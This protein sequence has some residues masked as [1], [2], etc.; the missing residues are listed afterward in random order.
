M[1]K[2]SY[3]FYLLATMGIWHLGRGAYGDATVFIAASVL[4]ELDFR[5]KH[6]LLKKFEITYRPLL[7]SIL[8]I[9]GVVLT[10]A[11]RYSTIN[12]FVL[13]ALATVSVLLI[14]HPDLGRKPEVTLAAKRSIRLW[15]ALLVLLCLI[16]LSAYILATLENGNDIDFPTITVLI[17]PALESAFGRAIFCIAWLAIG[18]RLLRPQLREVNE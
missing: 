13:Y 12:L 11:P 4:L 2:R 14:W 17:D 10:L 9:F 6:L 1:N 15:S 8:G 16:E 18:Y 3:W 7:I 5:N